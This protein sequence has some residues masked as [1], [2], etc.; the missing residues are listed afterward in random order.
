MDVGTAPDLISFNMAIPTMNTHWRDFY[1]A[2]DMTNEKWQYG[3]TVL[4]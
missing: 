3:T 1:H 4:T 2:T